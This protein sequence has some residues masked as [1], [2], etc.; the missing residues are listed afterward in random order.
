[1]TAERLHWLFSYGTLQQADVQIDLFGRRLRGQ[2]DT[3]TGFVS[4]PLHL[5]DTSPAAP[6]DEETYL[7]L[8]PG[9]PD[10]RVAGLALRVTGAELIAADAYE[11]DEYRRITVTLTSG[12][13]AF[14]YVAADAP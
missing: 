11:T 4:G 1:M 13:D 7:A 14:V 12:R 3:L 2:A 8:R 5:P 6:S 10:D 9:G